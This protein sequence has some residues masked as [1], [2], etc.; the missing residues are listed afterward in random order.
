ML[1]DIRNCLLSIDDYDRTKDAKKQKISLKF[2][3]ATKGKEAANA[4]KILNYFNKAKEDLAVAKES[5]IAATTMKY[6]RQTEKMSFV[7]KEEKIKSELDRMKVERMVRP[8]T[9]DSMIYKYNKEISTRNKTQV[10]KAKAKKEAAE[11]DRLANILATNTKKKKYQFFSFVSALGSNFPDLFVF[12]A[13]FDILM[14]R[15]VSLHGVPEKYLPETFWGEEQPTSGI[16][17]AVAKYWR[18]ELRRWRK[19][20]DSKKNV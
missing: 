13:E 17:F 6:E 15:I 4:T 19:K 3:G 18:G 1:L 5:V 9:I 16:V 20:N 7:I 8:E 11:E 10:V 2:I 12:L 14:L